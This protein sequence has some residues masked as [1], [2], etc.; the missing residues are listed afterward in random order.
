MIRAGL[1]VLAAG[2]RQNDRDVAITGAK[3]GSVNSG[4]SN[5]QQLLQALGKGLLF[6][7]NGTLVDDG[8]LHEEVWVEV[9][10]E[11]YPGRFNDEEVARLIRGR[12]N[13]DIVTGLLGRDPAKPELQEL[14]GEKEAR[15]RA[16]LA[17]DTGFA[18]APGAA[19]FLDQMRAA[20][21][22]LALA[23]LAP[24]ENVAY[25]CERLG[26]A[27]WFESSRIIFDDDSFPGKPAPDIF[28]KAA[29]ALGLK[30]GDCTV[31]GDAPADVTAASA[32]GVPLIVQVDLKSAAGVLPGAHYRIT[33]Y[34]ELL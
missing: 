11:R 5:P 33:S 34:G 26:L 16:R 14:A 8:S 6:D 3:G 9:V 29:D 4:I 28:L 23:T 12:S 30:A 27:R 18:L 24:A 21:R 32:A 1:I 7:F 15:Y 19:E 31:F 17:A 10:Q 2:L 25:F 20:G 22:G 13:R